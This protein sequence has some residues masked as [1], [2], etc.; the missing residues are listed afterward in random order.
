MEKGNIL[1]EGKTKVVKMVKNDPTKVIIKNKNVITKNDDPDQTRTM[2]RKA[3]LAT[4]ITCIV[5]EVLKLAGIPLAYIKKVGKTEFLAKL[6]RMISLEIVVRRYAVGSYLKRNPTVEGGKDGAPHRFTELCFE[7]FL[8][9]TGGVILSKDGKK[10]GQ[11]P[12]DQETKRP[13]DDPLI[14]NPMCASWKLY[15]PKKP[16]SDNSYLCTVSREDVLPKNA[17][18]EEIKTIACQVFL[19]I[20]DFLSLIN[21]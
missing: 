13:V 6:C 21:L 19:I 16:I 11:L 1:C 10:I 17:S 20:E 8:K 9:T 2:E 15:H 18:I 4:V 7:V 5:F 3:E 12:I 14:L